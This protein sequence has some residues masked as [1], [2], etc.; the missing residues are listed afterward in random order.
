MN[1][2]RTGMRISSHEGEPQ[3]LF[4]GLIQLNRVVGNGVKSWTKIGYAPRDNLLGNRIRI[5]EGA[6]S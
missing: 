3:E 2:K 4:D 1:S 5:E 6:E